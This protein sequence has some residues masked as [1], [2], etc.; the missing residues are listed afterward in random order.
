MYYKIMILCN[1]LSDYYV[2]YILIPT[3]SWDASGW[4]KAEGRRIR[5]F[6]WQINVVTLLNKNIHTYKNIRAHMH[7]LGELW[8]L[9]VLF[10]HRLLGEC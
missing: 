3:A 8:M 6:I 2:V 1:Y 5:T 4:V 7:E 10:L 9:S